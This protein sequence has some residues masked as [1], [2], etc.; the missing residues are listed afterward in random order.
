MTSRS[1]VD[2][3]WKKFLHSSLYCRLKFAEL[4]CIVVGGFSCHISNPCTYDNIMKYGYYFPHYE[5]TRYIQCGPWDSTGQFSRCKEHTCPFG[6]VWNRTISACNIGNSKYFLCCFLTSQ[7]ISQAVIEKRYM[8]LILT[9]LR[10]LSTYV[11]LIRIFK[12]AKLL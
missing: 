5:P 3:V 7:H 2:S 9:R 11:K 4:M 8:S 10:F 12:S 6:R 1:L